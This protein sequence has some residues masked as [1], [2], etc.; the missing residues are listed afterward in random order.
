[1]ST[2]RNKLIPPRSLTVVEPWKRKCA[3]A[4]VVADA[5]AKAA[6]LRCCHCGTLQTTI[7]RQR[8]RHTHARTHVDITE[9]FIIKNGSHI[10]ISNS[11]EPA[12]PDP[13]P[14]DDS[15]CCCQ[16][17]CCEDLQKCCIQVFGRIQFN[18][19]INTRQRMPPFRRSCVVHPFTTSPMY[20]N[21]PATG[22]CGC[23]IW[24]KSK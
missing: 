17:F 3:E 15:G 4:W 12:I 7:K 22:G 16:P 11:M 8:D 20:R 14:I 2:H 1:M 21:R 18:Q 23:T 9:L 6:A 10:K 24:R 13:I 19:P 5:N